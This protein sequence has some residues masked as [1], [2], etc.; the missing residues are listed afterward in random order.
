MLCAC[1]VCCD[2]SWWW[3]WAGT[4]CSQLI[5]RVGLVVSCLVVLGTPCSAMVVICTRHIEIA[6]PKAVETAAS[7]HGLH[8]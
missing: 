6:T 2:V 8:P 1:A 7:C 3:Q 4:T 5:G